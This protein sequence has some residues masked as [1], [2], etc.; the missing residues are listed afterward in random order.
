MRKTEKA[1]IDNATEGQPG[2]DTKR[3]CEKFSPIMGANLTETEGAQTEMQR[4]RNTTRHRHKERVCKFQP[5]HG[6][7]HDRDG[8][9]T[10]RKTTRQKNRQAQTQREGLQKFR[11]IMGANMTETERA[12]T[13]RQRDR[14]ARHRHKER[15]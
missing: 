7:K 8:E 10:D 14:T 4:D 6:S 13:G 2:T 5:H 11:P 9:S 12:Q 1:Q 3:G 15:A